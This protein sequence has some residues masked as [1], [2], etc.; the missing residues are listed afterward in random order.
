MVPLFCLERGADHEVPSGPDVGLCVW[1]IGLPSLPADLR[2]TGGVGDP[3]VLGSAVPTSWKLSRA[4]VR[5]RVPHGLS[6]VGGAAEDGGGHHALEG[7][8]GSPRAEKDSS[9]W[10]G[11]SSPIRLRPRSE[12]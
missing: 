6:G 2:L 5:Q 7:P 1:L 12:L 8:A 10:R 4:G 3:K 9:R 11:H